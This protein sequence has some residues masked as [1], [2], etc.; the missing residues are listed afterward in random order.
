MPPKGPGDVQNL[1]AIPG[2]GTGDE[3]IKPVEKM[4]SMLPWLLTPILMLEQRLDSA[5]FRI[6]H[7]SSGRPFHL[8]RSLCGSRS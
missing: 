5:E 6:S 7:V 1:T 2:P 4:A 8:V 3:H